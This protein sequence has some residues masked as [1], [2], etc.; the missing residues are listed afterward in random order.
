R[1]TPQL[2]LFFGSIRW[3]RWGGR[4]PFLAPDGFTRATGCCAHDRQGLRASPS[5]GK[6]SLNE[7]NE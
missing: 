1:K 2:R 5:A 6:G 3:G 7:Q 4:G